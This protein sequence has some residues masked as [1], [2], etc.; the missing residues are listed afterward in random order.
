MKAH[1]R[2]VLTRGWLWRQRRVGER[3]ETHQRVITTRWW[4][5]RRDE[6]PPTNRRDSWVVLGLASCGRE[7]NPPTSHNDSLVVCGRRR[8]WEGVAR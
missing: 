6:S 2:V 7:L 8:V 4:C 3:V 5:W 1:P